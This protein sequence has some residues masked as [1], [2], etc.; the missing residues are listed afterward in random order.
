MMH[1][2]AFPMQALWRIWARRC[3]ARP[4]RRTWRAAGALVHACGAPAPISQA[5]RRDACA[6]ERGAASACNVRGSRASAAVACVGARAW[7][8]K[9]PSCRSWRHVAG[10]SRVRS[11]AVA[12]RL[13]PAASWGLQGGLRRR[14]PLGSLTIRCRQPACRRCFRWR[15]LCRQ[16]AAQRGF[17]A[18]CVA[19][20]PSRWLLR[21]AAWG[22]PT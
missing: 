8:D 11:A 10:N 18:R 13:W 20:R 5:R 12:G 3:R 17:R 4:V 19:P 14:V 6:A 21:P 15:Q 1:P 22:W 2:H 9:T 7:H 16:R